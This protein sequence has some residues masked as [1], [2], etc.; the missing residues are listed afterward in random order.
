MLTAGFVASAGFVSLASFGV[1]AVREFGL[2]AAVGILSALVIELTFIPA[3]RV[4][5]PA[6]RARE[7]Q[8]ERSHGVVDSILFAIVRAVSARPNWVLIAVGSAVVAAGTGILRLEVNT[9]FRSWFLADAPVIVADLAIRER[10]TGTSTIRILVEGD[11]AEAMVD[12]AVMQGIASLQATLEDDPKI[13]ATFSAAGYLSMLNRALNGDD[14]SAY[15]VPTEKAAVAQYL[16]VFGSEDLERV[17][18]PDASAAAIYALSRSDDVAWTADL[19]QRL[20]SVAAREFP[21]NVSVEIAGGELAEALA[22]NST[23]VQ[24]KLENILQVGAVIFILSSLVFRSIV[25]GLLVLAP[26]CC[27]AIVNMGLMGW[28]GTWLSFATATYTSMGVSLGADFAIYLL[29]R[30]REEGREG[31]S[32]DEAVRT[33]LLTSGRAIFFVASAIAA[34]YATL[35][36]S[37]FVPWR[38]LGVYV[39]LMMASSAVATVTLVPALLLLNPPRFLAAPAGRE[40]RK[41][42]AA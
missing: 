8:R 4:L 36:A 21:E 7:Q 30:V 9:S 42:R 28:F 24:E 15:R 23:V 38:Q 11:S 19:F 22:M 34:G 6:P 3:C 2:M 29:F 17:L 14:P 26:L 41:E 20:E 32:F 31:A 12:P 13:S 1:P 33:A 35:V 5:L 18:T 25:G 39:S 27:A 16:L 10:F 40:N 37:G